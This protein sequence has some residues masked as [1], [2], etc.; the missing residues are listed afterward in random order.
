MQNAVQFIQTTPRELAELINSGVKSQLDDF[1][2]E[3]DLNQIQVELLTRQETCD[4]L[5]IDQSTLYH[6]TKKGKVICYGMENRR[7]YKRSEIMECLT[8]LK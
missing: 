5:K 4:L 8:K 6:W 2:R 1:K 3:L 7:Y